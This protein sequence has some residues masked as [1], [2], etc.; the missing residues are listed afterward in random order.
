MTCTYIYVIIT[1]ESTDNYYNND[2]ENIKC[3]CITQY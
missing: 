3:I 2:K 1:Y